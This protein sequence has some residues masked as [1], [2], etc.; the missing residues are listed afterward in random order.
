VAKVEAPSTFPA[1]LRDFDDGSE[2]FL[3]RARGHVGVLASLEPPA[4]LRADYG[5]MVAELERSERHARTVQDL[6][7]GKNDDTDALWAAWT[8]SDT[9]RSQAMEV[10]ERLELG[11]CTRLV[12]QHDH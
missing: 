3:K 11:D 1:E 8:A 2:A 9:S 7:R 5:R 12:A 6:V 10:A 4:G